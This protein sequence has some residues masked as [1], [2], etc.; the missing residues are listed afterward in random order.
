L[1]TKGGTATSVGWE[2]SATRAGA[3]SGT[4]GL[5]WLVG[6]VGLSATLGLAGALCA[7]LALLPA[8]SNIH[9]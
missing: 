4:L 2:A 9:A 1:S 6:A 7:V 3:M 8:R 5:G